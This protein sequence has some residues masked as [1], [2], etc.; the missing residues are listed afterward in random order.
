VPL[1]P[2]AREILDEV[3]ASGRLNAHLLPIEEARANFE[4]LFESLGP[5]PEVHE[6]RELAIPG[7]GGPIGA[8][9][10]RPSPERRPLVL[11]FHGGGWLIGSARAFDVVCRQLAVASGCA[12][13]SV[14]Y[15]LAPEHPFPA[16]VED[17]WD[18][19]AWAASHGAELGA[20][21]ERLAV[22]GDSAGG[23]LAAVVA[24]LARDRGGPALGFQLLVY[25]V[26]T[27]DLDALDM[28]YEGYFLYRDEL[29][30]HQQHYLGAV[31]PHPDWRVC[32][33][34]APSFAGLPPAFVLTAECDLLHPHGEAY[35]E[36]LKEAGVP[37]TLREYPGMIHGF[38][39][40]ESVFEVASDAM[41]DAGE[42]LRRALA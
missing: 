30:W 25:P 26:V 15:R 32:V 8:R 33:L 31:G 42:A 11:Y 17:A 14:D 29:A 3:A 1:D 37:V 16:A 19:T 23:N 24:H 22:A 38:F 36:R 10:Y 34:D 18:A 35:A 20:D 2:K 39:G 28:A 9:L 13:L 12:V 6:A 40:L 5:G 4:Q 27:T 7:S 41:R 21:P